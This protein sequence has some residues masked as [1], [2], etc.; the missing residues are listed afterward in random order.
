M[1]VG[2]RARPDAAGRVAVV[3]AGLAG[4]S[5]AWNLRRLGFPV[6]IFERRRLVGGKATS[7][8]SGGTEF[9]NGQ[10]V[11]LGCFREWRLLVREVGMEDAIYLQ[12]RFEAL[13]IADDGRAS[14]LRAG[15]LPAPWHL[16]PALF[17]HRLLGLRGRFDV[18]RAMLAAGR[19]TPLEGTF[20]DWLD[21][22]GQGSKA[23]GGFWTPFL[24]PSLN[25]PLDEV[26]AEAGRFV[27]T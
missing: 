22:L 8:E 4:L 23:R 11:F 27:L 6:E 24:V 2:V 3:G 15:R 19:H 14:R 20:S 9:D 5:A 21:R 18:A 13:L 10:H 7:F 26:E 25:A 16:L 12:P 1:A 17:G